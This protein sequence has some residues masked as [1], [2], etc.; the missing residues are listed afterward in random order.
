MARQVGLISWEE[1]WKQAKALMDIQENS[2]Q[3]E[4]PPF[5]FDFHSR[6]QIYS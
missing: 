3:L 1:Y 2:Q 6:V 5:D 4:W